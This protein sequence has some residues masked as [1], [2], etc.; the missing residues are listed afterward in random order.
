[1]RK[2]RN[3]LVAEGLIHGE[4]SYPVSLTLIVAVLML[5]IG[6]FAIGNMVV[7]L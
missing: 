3:R 2:E 6:F 7:N 5:V 4:S 1:L